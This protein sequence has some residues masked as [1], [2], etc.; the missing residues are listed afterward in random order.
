MSTVGDPLSAVHPDSSSKPAGTAAATSPSEPSSAAETNSK[1]AVN[2]GSRSNTSGANDVTTN[3]SNDSAL[4]NHA[5]S[6]SCSSAMSE[7][8]INKERDHYVVNLI[9]GDEIRLPRRQM[10]LVVLREYA[11]QKLAEDEKVREEVAECE[12]ATRE[13]EEGVLTADEVLKEAEE[14][15]HQARQRASQARKELEVAFTM[16]AEVRKRAKRA[17]AALADAHEKITGAEGAIS[18]DHVAALV[19]QIQET[20]AGDE[21]DGE[22]EKEKMNSEGSENAAGESDEKNVSHSDGAL[23]AGKRKREQHESPPSRTSNAAEERS[24]RA[25]KKEPKWDESL[26]SGGEKLLGVAEMDAE[27]GI[28]FNSPCRSELGLEFQENSNYASSPSGEKLENTVDEKSAMINSDTLL[29]FA[30]AAI[31]DHRAKGG[32]DPVPLPE[33]IF[34]VNRET[35]ED[36]LECHTV[37]DTGL[38]TGA[39][40]VGVRYFPALNFDVLLRPYHALSRV[41]LEKWEEKQTNE[42]IGSQAIQ[43]RRGGGPGHGDGANGST[44][45]TQYGAEHA[46]SN[47]ALGN[48]V[49]NDWW[50]CHVR[51]DGTHLLYSE[52]EATEQVALNLC[53]NGASCEDGRLLLPAFFA[54]HTPE[55]ARG[56]QVNFCTVDI[57]VPSGYSNSRRSFYFP[58][59]KAF[60]I[61]EF[62]LGDSQKT[63]EN[64]LHLFPQ[65]T[66]SLMSGFAWPLAGSDEPQRG[67]IRFLQ[68]A[69]HFGKSSSSLMRSQWS[70]PPPL[71]RTRFP[72]GRELA[73]SPLV[74]AFDYT[75]LPRDRVRK[76]IVNLLQCLRAQIASASNA[77]I[78]SIAALHWWWKSNV[79]QE[80]FSN[81]D[82]WERRLLDLESTCRAELDRRRSAANP[83]PARI[84][85]CEQGL[86]L[87]QDLR[88]LYLC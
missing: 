83:D 15:V 1:S 27:H 37:P 54:H 35:A 32:L 76:L 72:G 30:F 17:G 12:K 64:L 67:V 63:P 71:L 58:C 20:K 53:T 86:Y 69:M 8:P 50:E 2:E 16:K 29:R 59:E 75:H 24:R 56:S 77:E 74:Q 14:A 88:D 66:C 25:R 47:T 65:F 55:L 84:E 42:A 49:D 9:S 62:Q 82:A 87:L 80:R 68:T 6:E 39:I 52:K 11:S 3:E 7:N 81:S 57:S 21:D 18:T 34:V 70:W 73:A 78:S 46:N 85:S 41:L 23:L 22:S 44:A 45:M 26:D 4:A 43:F 5:A 61:A 79:L 10:L 48:T 13:A 33:L 36:L 28:V 31:N 19:R 38:L 51:E 40:S 60:I